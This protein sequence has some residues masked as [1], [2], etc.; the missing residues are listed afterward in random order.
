MNSRTWTLI[1]VVLVLAGLAA[2]RFNS[3]PPDVMGPIRNNMAA[4]EDLK[5]LPLSHADREPPGDAPDDDPEFEIRA[6]VNTAGGKS[7]LNYYISESHGFYVQ[8][9][10]L[11]FWWKQRPDMTAEDSPLEI[12]HEANV[13]IEAGKEL[14]GCIEVVPAELA[15]VGGEMGTDDN[16]GAEVLDY[17]Y[18]RESNPAE[19]P[20]LFERLKCD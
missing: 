13:Y 11:S 20:E 4:E 12:T 3:P 6:E 14:K 15:S 7:R 2:W 16:W 19:L 1:I 8:Y 18:V 5:N 10:Q 9:L 17:W